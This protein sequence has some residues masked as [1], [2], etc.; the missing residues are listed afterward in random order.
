MFNRWYSVEEQA[1]IMARE[2]DEYFTPHQNPSDGSFNEAKF[3]HFTKRAAKDYPSYLLAKKIACEWLESGRSIPQP[4]SKWIVS[5]L[6]GDS[7]VPRKPKRLDNYIR[8]AALVRAV[9][10]AEKL[11]PD[12][13][14]NKNNV[15]DRYDCS[16]SIVADAAKEAGMKGITLNSVRNAYKTAEFSPP[17][18]KTEREENT[19]S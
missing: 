11:F 12:I 17:L 8:H 1:A 18:P 19:V 7:K 14:R 15:T 4:V 3:K 13:Q 10:F 5:V 9:M 2:S 16:F 6:T